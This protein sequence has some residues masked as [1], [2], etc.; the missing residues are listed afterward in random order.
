MQCGKRLGVA[1]ASGT[2]FLPHMNSETNVGVRRQALVPSLRRNYYGALAIV[3]FPRRRVQV[4]GDME[5]TKADDVLRGVYPHSS[6]STRTT[7]FL[8]A[9]SNRSCAIQAMD[10]G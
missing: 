3:V 10:P 2:I 4:R 8:S 6:L 5:T 9:S 7:S 1:I